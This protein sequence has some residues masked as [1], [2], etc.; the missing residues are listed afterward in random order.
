MAEEV[1]TFDED[2]H[3]FVEQVHAAWSSNA[4]ISTYANIR[5]EILAQQEQIETRVATLSTVAELAYPEEVRNDSQWGDF[6]TRAGGTESSNG[7]DAKRRKKQH[8][9]NNKLRNL[10]IIAALWSPGIVVYYGWHTAA[11]GQMNAIRACAIR[12][13]RFLDLFCPPLNCVLLERH[14]QA[15]KN[16]KLKTLAEAPIQPLR[17]F[18]LVALESA[19]LDNGLEDQWT[20]N[21]DGRLPIDERG[22]LLC[23]L[24]P[25]HFQM[26][27]LKKDRYGVLTVRGNEDPRPQPTAVSQPLSALDLPFF[28]T[29]ITPS[30]DFATPGGLCLSRDV[31]YA[32]DLDLE[33]ELTIDRLFELSPLPISE[34]SLDD[35]S[36]ASSKN[37]SV[38]SPSASASATEP[39]SAALHSH[40]AAQSDCNEN[41]H[42]NDEADDYHMNKHHFENSGPA[43]PIDFS[44]VFSPNRQNL[45]ASS[46][47]VPFPQVPSWPMPSSPVPTLPVSLSSVA[48]SPM[49]SPPEELSPPVE[50]MAN[51]SADGLSRPTVGLL[52]PFSSATLLQ[53]SS[54]SDLTLASPF[55]RREHTLTLEESLHNRYYD[56]IIAYT[57]KVLAE[58]IQDD[59]GADRYLRS[60]WLNPATRWVS[61]WTQPGGKLPLGKARS[62]LGADVLYY[63][64]N[65][66][67]NHAEE[68]H[69]FHKPIVIKEA[70]S[71]SAMHTVG[72]LAV[73]LEDASSN[74]IVHTR[75]LDGDQPA[76]M[77]IDRLMECMCSD[78]HGGSAATLTLRNVTKAHKP[79]LTMLPRFRLLENLIERVREGHRGKQTASTYVDLCNGLSFNLFGL[80]GAFS[81]AYLNA[82]G[83][84]WVRNLDGVSFWTMVSEEDMSTEWEAFV[85]A[86][87]AWDPIGKQKFLVLEQDDV[88]LVP[89]GRK[90]VQVVHSPTKGVM[91][92]GILWDDFNV[93]QI[94]QA[95]YWMSKHQAAINETVVSKLPEIIAE[96]ETVV[97]QKPERFRGDCSEGDFLQAF[98]EAVSDLRDLGCQCPPVDCEVFCS[99]K[100]ERRVCTSWCSAHTETIYMACT[101]KSSAGEDIVDGDTSEVQYTS[102]SR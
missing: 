88:L 3:T 5:D 56:M 84:V 17:D 12:Y 37:M 26:Y 85:H 100:Q 73:L 89:P 24:R 78:R 83:A 94:L 4:P 75:Q 77:S 65:E 31:S 66:F 70:F 57:R 1:A 96:L 98:D 81:G 34:S 67:I 36:V 38:A 102:L 45:R 72:G 21:I 49:P 69:R 86:G 74:V 59:A 55:L 92:G 44:A 58:G 54:S 30:A 35:A 60:K 46:P 10:A 82:L 80:D 76:T 99:C 18:D 62:A 11:Q 41:L 6:S 47:Q 71:D 16:G 53:S 95:V 42:F 23:D 52:R 64:S 40:I 90:I 27:L 13:P 19:V 20:T 25:N 68:G 22:T 101:Q 63:T 48:S 32:L 28:Q 15:I 2:T 39:Y 61:V 97:R 50:V 87:D 51:N 9:K 7:R 8:N 93:L 91:E 29:S 79:L 43:T 14:R 33:N